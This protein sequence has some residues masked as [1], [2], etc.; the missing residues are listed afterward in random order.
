L[1]GMPERTS[2]QEA[3]CPVKHDQ[4][5]HLGQETKTHR[6]LWTVVVTAL[7]VLRPAIGI[8]VFL[9]F[10]NDLTVWA[11]LLFLLACCT[12]VLD[13]VVAKWFSVSPT[14]GPYS[15]PVADFLL[16]L[17][18]FSAFVVED[19][20]S[21]WILLLIVLMFVQFVLTS[22]LDRPVY[23]PAGKYY[24]AALFGAVAITL[25]SSSPIVHRTVLMG[26]V[27]YTLASAASRSLFL[28][29]RRKMTDPHR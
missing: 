29:R 26:V 24:G 4:H 22:G 28:V 3:A 18:S 9:T 21:T 10:V 16:I 17:A 12:D 5:G 11:L 25:I 13:G 2:S 7:V 14:L 15:D 8:L 27:L 20:Y 23:D 6:R 1:Y 19:I